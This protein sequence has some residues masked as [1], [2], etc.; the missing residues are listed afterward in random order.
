MSR[1]TIRTVP[2]LGERVVV[3]GDRVE[4]YELAGVVGVVTRLLQ[5]DR[6]VVVVETLAD[7]LRI[8]PYVS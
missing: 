3:C 2:A 4:I 7:K 5:P 6:E 1:L 8:A